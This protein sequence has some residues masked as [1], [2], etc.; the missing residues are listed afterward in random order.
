[1]LFVPQTLGFL[2]CIYRE[3]FSKESRLW[4]QSRNRGRGTS[5]AASIV[6]SLCVF[7]MSFLFFCNFIVGESGLV[8]G[9][10]T[11]Q[12]WTRESG[13][14]FFAARGINVF[15]LP[16]VLQLVLGLVLFLSLSFYVHIMSMWYNWETFEYATEHDR[17]L[18]FAQTTRSRWFA[19]VFV[20]YLLPLFA[21]RF[22]AGCCSRHRS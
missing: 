3:L 22:R 5:L 6:V 17:E 14:V 20:Y 15:P 1:M 9:L 19:T 4:K 10:G 2:K 8:K 21:V 7:T 13:L 18:L 16:L 11:T 12:S